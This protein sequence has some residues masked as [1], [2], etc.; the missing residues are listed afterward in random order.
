VGLQPLVGL[1]IPHG[2]PDHIAALRLT[3]QEIADARLAEANLSKVA[4]LLEGQ[5]CTR[6]EEPAGQVRGV[7]CNEPLPMLAISAFLESLQYS[8]HRPALTEPIHARWRQL[9]TLLGLDEPLFRPPPG[10]GPGTFVDPGACPY[11]IAAYLRLWTSVLG[12]RIAPGLFPTDAPQ[13]AWNLVDLD[14]YRRTAPRF[15]VAIRFGEGEL[16]TH[17]RLANHGIRVVQRAT[18]GASTPLIKTF[19]GTR[20]VGGSYFG[21]QMLD[22]HFHPTRPVPKLHEEPLWRPRGHPGLLLIYIAGTSVGL[23]PLVGLG[24]PHGGPDH[25][26]ALRLTAQA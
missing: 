20:G 12:I 23:Q 19:W 24:I 7:I 25:I 13:L 17:P 9:Q 8:R 6:I 2:G 14:A 15:Y 26:A 3:A 16:C 21:D 22:Y 5:K 4:D 11:S 18:Q 1:G 10:V